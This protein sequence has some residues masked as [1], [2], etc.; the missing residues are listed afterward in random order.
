M[1]MVNE[2][3]N[4]ASV[5]SGEPVVDAPLFPWWHALRVTPG[6]ERRSAD[7]LKLF[8]VDAYLPT[9]TKQIRSRGKLHRPRLYAVVSGLLF[10]PEECMDIP[11][12]DRAFE[13]CYVHG[14]IRTS[15]GQ[16]ARLTKANVEV[17]R[18]IEAILNLPPAAKGVLFKV[19]EDVRFTN[20]VYDAFLG[21]ARVVE[22]ASPRRIGVEVQKLIGGP[23]KMFVPA[24]EIERM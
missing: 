8:G 3:N 19:G 20:P 4:L 10:V 13:N 7:L 18:Q 22:I 1:L 16:P 6:R 9:F 14:F 2:P 15:T 5:V 17:V 12:R 23:R 11:Q 24:S 21:T